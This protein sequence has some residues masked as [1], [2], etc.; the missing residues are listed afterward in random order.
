MITK[1]LP[2]IVLASVLAGCGDPLTD[3]VNSRFPPVTEEGARQEAVQ[4]AAKSLALI[5][6]PN[7]AVGLN[8]KDAAQAILNDDLR[9]AGVTAIEMRGDEQLLQVKLRFKKQFADDLAIT[10]ADLRAAVATLSPEIE[11]SIDAFLGING[12]L[13][14][15]PGGS[16]LLVLKLLPGLSRVTVDSLKAA[17]LI[18]L[19]GAAQS[20][21]VVLT[22]YRDNITGE[23]VRSPLSTI[24][25]PVV[26]TTVTGITQAI[27]LKSD[28]T[29]AVVNVTT[30]PIQQPAQLQEIAWLIDDAQIIVLAGC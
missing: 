13:R 7:M 16:Q 14:A 27:H 4:G 30:S 20:I 24:M 10:D 21:A 5:T 11:G 8:L 3:L 23:L 12:E 17:E 22:H 26:P 2:A 28:G 19:T 29:D 6:T 25:F 18:D 15:D 9:A 1:W